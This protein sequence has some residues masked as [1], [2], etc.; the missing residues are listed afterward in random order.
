MKHKTV[1]RLFGT[2]I[3]VAL[4]ISLASAHV[5]V[6]PAEVGIGSSQT[7][8]VGVPNEKEVSTTAVRV[9]IPDGI[10]HVSPTVK[11]GWTITIKKETSNGEEKVTEITWT[12]GSV[13]ADQ[14]D[15]FTFSGQVPASE[16]ELQWK[17]Y[18]TYQDGTIVSWDQDPA[19][20]EEG[21]T[22]YSITKVTNDL[23]VSSDKK[24]DAELFTLVAAVMAVILSLASIG[25][26]W[27][28]R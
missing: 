2:I 25:L 1:L 4:N 13:P 3:A 27:K 12:N 5:V 6:K 16:G 14:R 23:V 28:K 10:K 17:A 21:T 7:F 24:S 26:Q 9:V 19:K 20:K 18:Q 15:D 11:P 8:T 22:P